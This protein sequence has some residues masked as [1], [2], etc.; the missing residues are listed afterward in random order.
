MAEKKNDYVGML[1]KAAPY[2]AGGVAL[3]F[4]IK[5][6]KTLFGQ[7]GNPNEAQSAAT[8][9]TVNTA[10]KQQTDSGEKPSYTDQQFSIYAD[11]LA[12]AMQGV[13]T[14][15]QSIFGI[16]NH[17]NSDLDI[18]KLVS[19]FGLRDY[20]FM[21]TD[22]GKLNLGEWLHQEL[23]TSDLQQVNQILFDQGISYQF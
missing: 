3:F 9:A 16:M 18:L 8:V 20:T 14:D 2:I 12:Q 15:E 10:I 1:L 7:G 19:A 22:Q 17:M 23:S 5:E 11:G 13:G 6:V 21:V 4:V